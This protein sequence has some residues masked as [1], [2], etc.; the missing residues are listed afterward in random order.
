MTETCL[1][2]TLP[3]SPKFMTIIIQNPKWRLPW[4]PLEQPL[5]LPALQRQLER[6]IADGHPLWGKDAEVLG[7]RVDND[8]VLV[9]CLDG[10]LATVHLDWA[11]GPH[12][13][14]LGYPSTPA[15]ISRCAP[16]GH[17]R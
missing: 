6:E 10:T 5:D 14:P 4:R 8:D 9:S 3:S 13:N 15:S 16:A 1:Q 17:R 11:K 7:C 12:A 2:R